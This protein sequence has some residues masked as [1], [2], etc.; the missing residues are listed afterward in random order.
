MAS[1][2]VMVITEE[3]FEREVVQSEVP[4][5]LDFWAGWCAPCRMLSPTI[6]SLA[7]E[8]EGK[9]KV[10]K[11]NVDEQPNLAAAFQVMSIPTVTLTRGK[12]MLHQS[13]GVKTKDALKKEIEARI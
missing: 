4:V 13:I 6:D 7:D 3:N 8:L 2:K 12:Q 1:E 9:I 5:L 11:V 10:G